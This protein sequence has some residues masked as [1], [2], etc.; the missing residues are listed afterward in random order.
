MS[1]PVCDDWLAEFDC[2]IKLTLAEDIPEIDAID[3]EVSYVATVCDVVLAVWWPLVV[4]SP[5]CITM[6]KVC[7][8]DP[9]MSL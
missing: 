6:S 5:V 7:H 1:V 8:F 9:I 3:C 2:E 4:Y